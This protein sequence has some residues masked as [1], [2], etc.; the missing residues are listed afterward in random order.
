MIKKISVFLTVLL[1]VLSFAS[2][3]DD[4]PVIKTGWQ[5]P[6]ESDITKEEEP[7]ETTF[8]PDTANPLPEEDEITYDESKAVSI[9]TLNSKIYGTLKI[10]FQDG[11]FLMI[12]E[13]DDTKFTVFANNFQADEIDP[14]FEDMNFDGH[15]D[16]AV[17]Y[18]RDGLNSFYYCFLWNSNEKNYVYENQLS[19]LANPVFDATNSQIISTYK[20]TQTLVREDIYKFNGSLLQCLVSEEKEVRPEAET[21]PEILECEPEILE[22][23]TSALITL[24][25][26]EDS[27]SKW[28]CYIDDESIVKL[29]SG[30]FDEDELAYKFLIVCEAPGTTTVIF[31]FEAIDSKEYVE[32]RIINVIVDEAL[33]IEVIVP[34]ID[35]TVTEETDTETTE[36]P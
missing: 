8:V 15:N 24:P 33:N 36:A 20:I 29:S 3:K 34:E 30:Y 18:D 27:H 16:F 21:G 23:A 35:D 4:A 31:R 6:D 10:F 25:S 32:E 2:C 28:V 22:N 26:K 13:Y 5:N 12:D 14:I 9:G 1:M 7:E 17:C 19:G 11:Y